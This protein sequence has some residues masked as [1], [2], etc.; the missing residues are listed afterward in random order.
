MVMMQLTSP[1]ID[2]IGGIWEGMSGSP[3]YA[4]DGSLIGAVAYTLSFGPTPI[5]G[6]TPWEDM[7]AHAGTPAAPLARQGLLGDRPEDRREDRRDQGPG[8]LRLP[9]AEDADRPGRARPPR[10]R[11]ARPGVPTS[12]PR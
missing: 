8:V 3:V 12:A 1:E 2:S 5:A 7:Q 10:P 11:R 6:I 4:A 9:R